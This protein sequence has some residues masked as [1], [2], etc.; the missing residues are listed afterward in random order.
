MIRDHP[1]LQAF[2]PYLTKTYIVP[3]M[4]ALGLEDCGGRWRGLDVLI[5]EGYLRYDE[6][7][8]DPAMVHFPTRL[9]LSDWSL[10]V[11]VVRF[12]PSRG[13][14]EALVVELFLDVDL[15]Y[16]PTFLTAT[17]R[18]EFR[19]RT[20]GV[21]EQFRKEVEEK[22][23]VGLNAFEKRIASLIVFVDE[24]GTERWL[25]EE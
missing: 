12:H 8:L 3:L 20:R 24:D 15:E 14:D 22:E 2:D 17:E 11:L 7:H 9:S 6:E 13:G 23:K 16:Q 4:N 25:W 10:R 19:G 1:D 21:E 18:I 5:F